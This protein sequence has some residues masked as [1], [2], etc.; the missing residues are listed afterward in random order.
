MSEAEKR[1]VHTDALATLGTIIDST[2]GRDAIHLAVEPV[3]A[4]HELNPG[5]DVGLRADGRAGYSDK[6][7]GIV[8]PFLKR[9][10]EAGERFWLIVYPRQITSLRHVWAHP[11]IPEAT[12]APSGHSDLSDSLEAVKSAASAIGVS[13]EELM[14]A[15]RWYLANTTKDSR[16]KVICFGD[17]IDARELP[18]GFWAHY[19]ALSGRAVPAELRDVY[20]RCAC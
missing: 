6:P 15:I 19:E 2:A 10:V 3:I 7:L 16:D 9:P 18:E 17:E 12:T 8:D 5:Q 11:A 4:A 1:S 20:F 14:E 13:F